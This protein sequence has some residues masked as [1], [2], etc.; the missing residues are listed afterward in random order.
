MG[1]RSGHHAGRTDPG[2]PGP[3]APR[4]GP[5]GPPRTG[6]SPGAHRGPPRRRCHRPGPGRGAADLTRPVP[7]RALLPGQHRRLPGRHRGSRRLRP[8]LHRAGDGCRQDASCRRVRHRG[9]RGR[10][11]RPR[12]RGVAGRPGRGDRC[13]PG[14]RRAGRLHGRSLRAAAGG[15]AEL[16]R[17][18][19]ARTLRGPGGGGAQALR[20]AGRPQRH[21]HHHRQ[22][23]RAARAP[24][25]GRDCAGGHAP[26]IRGGRH[27]G[28]QR[29]E[30]RADRSG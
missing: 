10:P 30:H 19:R 24:A 2:P 28:L 21:R 20:R 4:R 3:H 9:G 11:G 1:C 17:R 18:L 26:G 12:D 29:R 15:G 22:H 16:H 8:G 6:P 5:R 13:P 27:G 14:G 23:P 25:A 7:R